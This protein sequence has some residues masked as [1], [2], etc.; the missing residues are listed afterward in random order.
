MEAIAF[1]IGI[2][3]T[4]WI[5]RLWTQ[6]TALE[7]VDEGLA[8]LIGRRVQR[9][10]EQRAMHRQ[11]EE[12]AEHIAARITPFLS[13]EA[14]DIDT[15]ELASAADA[16]NRSLSTS[17]ALDFS[18]LLSVDL[19]AASLARM[20]K[21]NDPDA[22]TS[23]GLGSAGAAVYDTLITEC[24]NYITSIALKLPGFAT[25]QARDALAR[26]SRLTQLA[27][28]IIEGLPP[29]SV[30]TEW[31]PG[32]ADQRFENKYRQA[33]SEFSDD[34]HLFGVTSSAAKNHYPLS[35]AYISLAVDEIH[36]GLRSDSDG[37][38]SAKTKG[39]PESTEKELEPKSSVLRIET[40]LDDTDR[41]LLT[42]GAGSGK[43]TLIQ[44]IAMTSIGGSIENGLADSWRRRVPFV[45]P[46]RRYVDRELP[47]P[48]NFV[49][50]IAENLVGAMPPGWV[51][52]TLASGRATLLIDGL[53][54]VPRENREAARS[55]ALR[56]MRDFP[57]SKVLITSR[58]TAITK[59]W[60]E[61]ATFRQ[62]ELLPL[63][64]SDIRSFVAHWHEATRAVSD[65]QR[66]AKITE[67]EKSML[68]IMRDRTAIRSLCTSPLLCALICALHLDSGASLPNNRMGV[69]ATALEML[70]SRR[71]SDRK[72]ETIDEI[73]LGYTERE[74]LLRSFAL[75]MHDNGASDS[76]KADYESKI[77]QTLK[78][79]HRVKTSPGDVASFLLERSGVLREPIAG[80]VDFVHRTFLEYLAAAEI[81]DDNSIDKLISLAH[82]DHWHEVIIMASGHANGPQRAQLLEGL[83]DRGLR[84]EGLKHKLF[85]LAVAC[86][87]TSPNLPDKILHR[88]ESA[89]AEV[90]PPR[91]MREATAVAS[92]GVIAVPMLRAKPRQP[93][94]E[95]A[96]CV[97]ALSL[98]G[99]EEAL[100]AIATFGRDRR[101]T[102]A[103]QLIRA[104]S[105]FETERYAKEVLADSPLDNG[106]I[107]ISDPEHAWH[108]GTLRRAS[109]VYLDLPGRLRSPFDLPHELPKV[110]GMDLSG[111]DWIKSP[112]DIPGD[113]AVVSLTLR[114]C[115]LETLRGIERVPS[116]RYL[117]LART[118]NLSDVS[119][120]AKL[121]N[122][123]WLDLSGTGVEIANFWD[124]AHPIN[125]VQLQ[126]APALVSLGPAV[127]AVTLELGYAPL[128]VD[129]TGIA[130][131]TVLKDLTLFGPLPAVSRLI[132]PDSLERL[133]IR[134]HDRQQLE[135][136][137]GA[138]LKRLSYGSRVSL[139]NLEWMI[140][141]R[142]LEDL[143]LDLF[144][145]DQDIDTAQVLRLLTESVSP[146]VSVLSIGGGELVE[147]PG[148]SPE[149]FSETYVR[150]TRE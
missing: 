92:A 144:G 67:A 107:V 46:L 69:Y 53:D 33:V 83:L 76:K 132:I 121:Q 112:A 115:P 74:I 135:L 9:A 48:D 1:S 129:V 62:A 38:T 68:A 20:V 123:Q 15:G 26:S 89:L 5:V 122:L 99:G 77:A 65:G 91:T 37:G 141:L 31:G 100:A 36:G 84:E 43:T 27:I 4:K 13:V 49:E 126:A 134:M 56:L 146:Q 41:L 145:P 30:P 94:Q 55:W 95:A 81:M 104:W 108:L 75:W 7:A 128:L 113:S 61:D 140:S 50:T 133:R 101:V 139:Q 90:L 23:A 109:A 138:R 143:D 40:L 105:S 98:I 149:S 86:M 118:W 21:Y 80:R 117:S 70:V 47:I 44:W 124:E 72:I 6:D 87:E 22:V 64:Y 19:S 73:E 147:V 34:L 54:E 10:N 11:F 39:T 148:W 88:L 60:E 93:W 66:K 24:A 131:S 78:G 45:I 127:N 63:E 28:E 103:R 97:R 57:S 71:D 16:A 29:S 35:V 142:E 32:S 12:L 110:F 8:E 96:A 58:T 25:A 17:G 59:G 3:A 130:A 120:L 137:G 18:S 150:Y 14:R 116:L 111:A 102:V 85:L 2:A 51:H 136:G 106:R 42:G 52:R 114:G 125:R 119:D 79:L 82:E